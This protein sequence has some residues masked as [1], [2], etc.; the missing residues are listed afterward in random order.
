MHQIKQTKWASLEVAVVRHLE[1]YNV[2]IVNSTDL[3]VS[4]KGLTDL[5]QKLKTNYPNYSNNRPYSKMKT[6]LTHSDII[7]KKLEFD[8]YLATKKLRKIFK[9]VFTI[10]S[11]I[12]KMAIF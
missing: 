11:T 5:S 8:K 2:L 7:F 3:V 4:N 6:D 10:Y 12:F 1:Q 9:Y